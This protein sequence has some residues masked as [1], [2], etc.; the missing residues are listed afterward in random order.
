VVKYG[1][2]YIPKFLTIFKMMNSE[3]D[4]YHIDELYL[5]TYTSHSNCEPWPDKEANRKT[6]GV[7]TLPG[8]KIEHKVPKGMY[9]KDLGEVTSLKKAVA[10]ERLRLMAIIRENRTLMEKTLGRLLDSVVIFGEECAITSPGNWPDIDEMNSGCFATDISGSRKVHVLAVKKGLEESE[11]LFAQGRASCEYLDGIHAKDALRVELDIRGINLK[12]DQW[13]KEIHDDTGCPRE[14]FAD[15]G[16]LLALR[17]A[18]DDDVPGIHVPQFSGMRPWID[19][20]RMK[21]EL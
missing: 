17:K 19:D 13:T 10:V 3:R 11:K 14:I 7:I 8:I 15:I 5:D 21:F 6:P 9:L 1:I 18:Q 20:L 16:G 12:P 4:P 2:A